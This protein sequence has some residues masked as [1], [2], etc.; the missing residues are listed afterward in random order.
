M[1]ENYTLALSV[2]KLYTFIFFA[3]CNLPSKHMPIGEVR[4]NA[5]I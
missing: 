4:K 2:P 3:I 1:E 5:D